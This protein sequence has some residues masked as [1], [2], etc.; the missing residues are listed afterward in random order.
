MQHDERHGG[1]YDRGRA[2]FFYGRRY[3]PHYFEAKTHLSKEIEDDMSVD[4]I[5]AYRAGYEDAERLGDQ[6]DWGE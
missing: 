2:D 3:R 6:K 4:E 5:D 1:P